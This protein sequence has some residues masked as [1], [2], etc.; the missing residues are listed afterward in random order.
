MLSA[1]RYYTFNTYCIYFINVPACKNIQN[2]QSSPL[3]CQSLDDNL[4][5]MRVLPNMKSLP[6]I[7]AVVSPIAFLELSSDRPLPRV[8]HDE[9]ATS[10]DFSSELSPPRSPQ[11]KSTA[12]D[13]SRYHLALLW[14]GHYN[15]FMHFY[16][17]IVNTNASMFAP[18]PVSPPKLQPVFSSSE[19]SSP[20]PEKIS[21]EDLIGVLSGTLN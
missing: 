5:P 6:L 3:S 1:L 9:V 18:L 8:P 13:Q 21:L 15:L 7:E 17:E 2:S 16:I 10:G 19:S 14:Q 11:L 12:R 20:Q 4:S